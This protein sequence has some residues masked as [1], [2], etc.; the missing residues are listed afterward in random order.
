MFAAGTTDPG[1]MLDLAESAVLGTTT[2]GAASQVASVTVLDGGTATLNRN[3]IRMDK[4]ISLA[5]SG[6]GASLD[7]TSD[8]LLGPPRGTPC[9]SFR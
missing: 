4:G 5:V 1:S 7:A 6:V 3:A 8:L 2:L 9:P